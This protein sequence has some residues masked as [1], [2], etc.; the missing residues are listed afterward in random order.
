M[1]VKILAT[2]IAGMVLFGI[3]KSL[4]TEWEGDVE[5]CILFPFAYLL[6]GGATYLIWKK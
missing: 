6:V 4:L 1:K 2:I 5:D 3:T